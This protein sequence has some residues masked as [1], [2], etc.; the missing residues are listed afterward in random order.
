MTNP[1]TAHRTA[2]HVPRRPDATRSGVPPA[3]H[4]RG[5]AE[6][7]TDLPWALRILR[8]FLGATFLFAGA[9][10]LL[11]PN[12]LRVGSADFVG[13]QLHGFAH[14]T[15][16]GP[17]LLLLAH[18]PVLAGV[19]IA[20]IEIAIGV[21]T[22]MG[23]AP[24]TAA[25]GGFA[26]SLTLLLSATWH[27]HPYF[28]GSDSIYA[29]AWLALFAGIWQMERARTGRL[30]GPL[31][32]IDHVDRRQFLRGAAVGGLTLIVAAAAKAF[33]GPAVDTLAAAP[34]PRTAATGPG[35]SSPPSGGTA[36]TPSTPGR[37]ITSL[38]RLPV[39]E[40]IGFTA[41]GVGAAVLVRLANDEVVAYSRT[42]TH[43]GCLV[44]YD[45]SNQILICPCHGAEFDPARGAAAIAGPT[46]TALP[47]VDVVVDPNTRSVILPS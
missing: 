13:T 37:R 36:G 33:S 27:V 18:A 20:L 42:C 16:A 19:A 29:V 44:G 12:F 21:G 41:P 24:L 40:A 23:V 26:V 46:S 35:P 32:V 3:P 11:D 4:E 38:D 39:G 43:A 28:L 2:R 8:G 17:L 9:Q 14:G 6:G 22:L 25:F 45:P 10:K 15:P 47:T 30:V 34:Q 7:W 31:E 5:F 1:T